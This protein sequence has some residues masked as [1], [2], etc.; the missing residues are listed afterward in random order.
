MSAYKLTRKQRAEKL[1]EQLERGPSIG[2]WAN[3]CP[4]E[5]EI[6]ERARLWLRS[7]ITPQVRLLVP[8]L[9]EKK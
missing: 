4:T 8:E 1:I 7:W 9:K 6:E 5:A 2:P 3:G